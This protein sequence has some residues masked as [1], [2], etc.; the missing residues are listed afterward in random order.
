MVAFKILQMLGAVTAQ[1]VLD[2]HLVT[3]E[4][5]K[6][7]KPDPVKDK[8]N[9]I[10]HTLSRTTPSILLPCLAKVFSNDFLIWLY[11]IWNICPHYVLKQWIVFFA[12][13]DWL[14]KLAISS[15][16]HLQAMSNLRNVWAKWLQFVTVT[17]KEISQINEEAVPDNMKIVTKFGSAVLQVNLGLFNLNLSYFFLFT[18]AN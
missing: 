14:L 18:N 12:H 8:K 7:W 1:G 9:P 4:L 17:N 15:A 5:V 13:S 6:V 2:Q 3:G 10:I 16:I 11:F